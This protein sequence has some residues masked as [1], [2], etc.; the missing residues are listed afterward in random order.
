MGAIKR[1]LI[2]TDIAKANSTVAR[3][4]ANKKKSSKYQFQKYNN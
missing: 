4:D 3:A 2:G 1:W